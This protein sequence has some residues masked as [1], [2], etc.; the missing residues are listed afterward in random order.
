MHHCLADDVNREVENGVDL[1][2][3]NWPAVSDAL[4]SCGRRRA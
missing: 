4:S 2:R 3:V 1:L